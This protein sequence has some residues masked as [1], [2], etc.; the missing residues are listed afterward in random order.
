M[1]RATKAADHARGSNEELHVTITELTQPG[2]EPRKRGV[3]A[4]LSNSVYRYSVV[5]ALLLMIVL[6]SVLEP[7]AFVTSANAKSILG[8][9]AILL[10]VALGLTIP[11]AVNEFDLSIGAV[12][13]FAQVVLAVLTV[14]H[15]W[16]LGPAVIVS[17]LAAL[18][19]G[20]INAFLVVKIGVSSFIATLGM[21]TLLGGLAIRLTDSAVI[22]GIPALVSDI[23]STEFLG[24]QAVFWYGVVLA[25]L[26]WYVLKFTPGGRWLYFTG[27]NPDVARL[28]GLPVDRLRAGALM[29]S[30]GVAGFAGI[31]YAGVYGAADPFSGEAFLL[32]AFAAV[33]LGATAFS[34]G[35]FNAWGTFF[36]VY[37][38]I[39]GIVGLGMVT[40][41]VGW[42]SNAFNGGVLIL[43]V[44]VQRIVAK[45]REKLGSR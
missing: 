3:A 13:G 39:T 4:L 5:W 43:A 22:P 16:A 28:N 35:R 30:A 8:S 9:Q 40:D 15:G 24:V 10:I 18:A 45:R 25:A 23:A 44:S 7:D 34:P 21:G 42:L 2:P 14:N 31:M 17:M 37:L 26:L 29:A 11:L 36:S 1:N 20:A 32:Q 12:V 27:A 33:F 6:F 38:V 19:I 41:Q